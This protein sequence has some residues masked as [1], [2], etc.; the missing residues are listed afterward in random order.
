MTVTPPVLDRT[1]ALFSFVS[2]LLP[3]CFLALSRFGV[4]NT[5]LV[6]MLC[7]VSESLMM[8]TGYKES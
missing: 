6:L 1:H 4:Y 8:L 3:H 2:Q 7:W 5:R